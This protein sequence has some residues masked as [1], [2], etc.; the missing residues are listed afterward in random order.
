MNVQDVF[1]IMIFSKL[2]AASLSPSFF[3]L[4]IGL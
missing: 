2:D 4:K 3:T 1:L